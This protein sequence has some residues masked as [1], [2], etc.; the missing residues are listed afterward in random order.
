MVHD[1]GLKAILHSDGDL[2]AILDQLYATGLDGYQ[3]VDP[4]GKM[5]I[6]IVREAYPDWILMG[7][8]KSSML[9]DTVEE[10][11][12]ES[13][14]YCMR[15]GGVGKRYILS[16]SNCIFAGMPVESYNIMLDE[17]RRIVSAVEQG[18]EF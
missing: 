13:V 14:R 3:S 12:R 7:N 6:K 15:Y 5:D 4:Q 1:T 8:V 18:Q 10:E 11:I 16:T 17:Y 9:Q 2:R